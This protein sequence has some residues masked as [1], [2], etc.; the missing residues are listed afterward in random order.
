MPADTSASSA[1]PVGCTNFKLRQLTRRV[2]QHYDQH[3]AGTGLKITQY[4]LLTH[5]DRLGPLAPGEL[6]RRMDM[7]ASTLTRNL[8]PMIAAGWL[9][10]GEG[11]DARSRTV[12][13]TEA[14]LEMRRQAQRR[15]KAAQ[16]A[17][18]E[19]LG[20]AT[21]AALHGLLDQGLAA[22]HEEDAY[23]E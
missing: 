8:Q 7:S 21:V 13:I 19:K 16:V 2:T 22:F 20:V 17:L 1:A 6:A 14:G 4:S 15:W 10:V 23:V 12:S 3:L 18:N 5:V 11:V 9:L